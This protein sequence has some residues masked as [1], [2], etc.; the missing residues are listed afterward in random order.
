MESFPSFTDEMV[1]H[2]LI[3]CVAPPICFS[4]ELED[5]SDFA[6]RLLPQHLIATYPEPSKKLC[7]ENINRKSIATVRNDPAPR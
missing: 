1:P 5:V 3:L 7:G 2:I 4:V 6:D